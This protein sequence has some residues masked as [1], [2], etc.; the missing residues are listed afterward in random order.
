[1][2]GWVVLAC[3]VPDVVPVAVLGLVDREPGFFFRLAILKDSG[4]GVCT[5]FLPDGYEF[6]ISADDK[7]RIVK[8]VVHDLWISPCAI[9][10]E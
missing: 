6:I 9:F 1:M 4:R 10:V 8:V 3:W 7:L 5:W 2:V